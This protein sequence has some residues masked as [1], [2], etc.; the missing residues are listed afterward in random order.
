MQFGDLSIANQVIGNFEGSLDQKPSLYD[1]MMDQA[2]EEDDV[3][4]E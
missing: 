4:T 2:T 3:K 1:T